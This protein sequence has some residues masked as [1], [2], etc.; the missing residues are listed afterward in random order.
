ML[1]LYGYLSSQQTGAYLA[2]AVKLQN[3]SLFSAIHPGA[4][5]VVLT[6]DAWTLAIGENNRS[7]LCVPLLRKRSYVPKQNT[8]FCGT[9]QCAHAL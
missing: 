9:M 6:A 7:E 8:G 2:Q 1:L 3:L 4:F 5:Y